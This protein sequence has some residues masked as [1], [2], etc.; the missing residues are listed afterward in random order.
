MDK[1]LVPAFEFKVLN[2]VTFEVL[3]EYGETFH[4]CPKS[5]SIGL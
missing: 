2:N 3:I 5:M 4:K 1:G